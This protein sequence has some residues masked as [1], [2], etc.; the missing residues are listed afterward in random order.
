MCLVANV[1]EVFVR[2]ESITTPKHETTIRTTNSHKRAPGRVTTGD[3]HLHPSQ[4]TVTR[5]LY[6]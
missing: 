6:N 1:K 3:L 5:S 2:I 4:T